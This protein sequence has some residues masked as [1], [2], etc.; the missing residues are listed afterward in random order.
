MAVKGMENESDFSI[1]RFLHKGCKRIYKTLGTEEMRVR[2]FKFLV[3]FWESKRFVKKDE[4]FFKNA[5][6]YCKTDAEFENLEQILEKMEKSISYV[7]LIVKLLWKKTFYYHINEIPIIESAEFMNK[8]QIYL[9]KI[10]TQFDSEI[11]H[12]LK[13]LYNQMLDYLSLGFHIF[14]NSL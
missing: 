4:F 3:L 7:P 2:L 13:T 11:N 5:V 14:L 9:D 12:Q 10:N 6:F 1:L 8:N